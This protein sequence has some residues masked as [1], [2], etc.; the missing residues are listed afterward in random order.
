M[1]VRQAKQILRNAIEN[2]DERN[3]ASRQSSTCS[4][5]PAR[6]AC[7]RIERDRQGAIRVFPGAS[8]IAK[9]PVA[10][11]AVDDADEAESVVDAVAEVETGEAVTV[12]TGTDYEPEPVVERPIV[13]ADV[14]MAGDDDEDESEAEEDEVNGNLGNRAE[15]AG[16]PQAARRPRGPRAAGRGTKTAARPRARKSSR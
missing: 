10:D 8:L 5:R 13:D 6:K 3:T 4:G 16:R 7:W 11:G 14:T 1:Y 15:E 2:F 12:E 9:P